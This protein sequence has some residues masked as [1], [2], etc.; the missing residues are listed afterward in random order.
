MKLRQATLARL[1]AS[2]SRPSFERSRLAPGIV[3]LGC[4]AFHR[5]HQAVFT[6]AAL[7]A[8]GAA[9]K[10]NW[11]ILGVSPRGQAVRDRLRAQDWLYTVAERDAAGERLTVIGVLT[12]VLVVP[13]DPGAVVTRIA[14]P[15]T[16]IV[17]TTVTE[18][19]YCHDPAT[20][21]LNDRHPYIIHDLEHPGAPLSALGL[22]VAGLERRRARGG[23]PLTVL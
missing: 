6:Q 1:P 13:E 11:G 12:Q 16:K 9:G 2:V 10:L 19:G 7:E 14:E 17:S 4:G 15:T 21:H 18:K 22:I 23:R 5:A 3:H 8:E 20:G